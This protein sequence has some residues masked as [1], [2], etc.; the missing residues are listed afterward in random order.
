MKTTILFLSLLSLSAFAGETSALVFLIA[1]QSNAGGVAAF[2][3]ESNVKSGIAGKH[4]AIPGS[5]ASEVG[6]PTTMDAYPRSYIW[7]KGF[8]RLKPGRNLKAGYKDPNRHGIELPM[9]MLLENKFPDADKFFIKH[10]P[11]G[12]NLH[13]QWK[14]GSGPD[15][16]DFKRQLDAAM[17]DL[18]KRYKN[19]R[20]IGLYWDQGE[21][22]KPEAN[23]YG[24]NLRA[25]FAAFRKDTG[26]P[27]LPIF[28]RKHLFQHG[29]EGFAPIIE[30]QVEVAKENP[31]THL[32]DLDLG[33]NERN[34]TAWAWTQNNGH[35]SSKAYLELSGRIMTMIPSDPQAGN[36]GM[37][38]WPKILASGDYAAIAKAY[39]DYMIDHGRDT[40]G[41]VHTPLFLTT[42]DRK[43]G[44]PFNPPYPRVIAKPFAP[45][46]RRDHKMRPYDRT[47]EGSNPLQDLPLYGLLYRLGELTGNKRYG[48]EADKSITWFF[49]NGWHSR[50]GLP[51]WG[52]HMY[53]DVNQDIPAYAG[54][55]PKKGY[56]GHEYNL[57]WPY[58][59][60]NP[61]ALKRF[62][63]GIWNGHIKD[64]ETG[65]FNRHSDDANVGM[66]FPE[67]GSC[68]LDIWAREYGR[69]GDPAMKGYIQKLL[70][71]YRS[72]RDP[73]TGAMSWCTSSEPTR[74]EM[75]NVQMNL[76]MASI[77]QDA[78]GHLDKRDPAL[79]R[80]MRGFVREMDDEYLSNEYDAILD[81]AGKGILS[82]YLVAD[83]TAPADGME[84]PPT[85]TDSSIGFPLKSADGKAAASLYYLAPWFP[86]RSYAG[87]GVLLK[88]RH[89][90]CEEKHTTSYRR[91]LLDIADIYMTIG[92]EVQFALYPDN[93][94]DVVELLRYVHTLTGDPAYLHRADQIMRLGLLLFFDDT[95]P[96]PKINNFD[97]WYESSSK[98]A[99]S[100]AILR[101]M[102]ELSLD[103]KALPESQRDAPVVK[104]EEQ[105]GIW[106]VRWDDASTD[107]LAR[108]G[109]GHELY[110]SRFKAEGGW[111][112]RLSDTITRIPTA[113]EADKLNGKMDNFTGKRSAASSIDYGDFKDAPQQVTIVIRNAGKQASALTVTANF[114]DTYH[115][116]GQQV[117]TR[118]VAPGKTELFAFSAS[119]KKWIRYLQVTGKSLAELSLEEIRFVF[120]PRNN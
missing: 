65:R 70:T 34:F 63:H 75:S 13:T 8:E 85:G 7:G 81:V 118:S 110:L 17:A 12:H 15:Y 51:A 60:Q 35:L 84:S 9:A 52:S 103:L 73:E 69:S 120:V 92:P 3:H 99:S 32:L 20:V 89:L 22:D 111:R 43:T 114:H 112:I 50:T 27:D 72:M 23:E 82:W 66:E 16:R 106:K 48:E 40:Y 107:L 53:Y 44:T 117:I 28:V 91:A 77:L 18:D 109:Q 11:A 83:R 42:L 90:R 58:W 47:Y 62:A 46:L 31:A 57:P 29:D 30:A 74:R 93:I 54:G 14:A 41:K 68:F 56:G 105:G 45:G 100:V 113:D 94:S 2:S 4:P 6:I 115:D 87:F 19:V 78:A 24:R 38:D 104:A 101:Q 71:L 79:A 49:K 10:G 96:L 86:G 116:N 108:Y 97:D 25:L 59:D 76:S 21:S 88:N 39:A 37:G 5:T 33:S 98:N 36:K 61:E 55:K 95:S 1:G 26:I 102:L 80:D 64:K 67:T 119:E